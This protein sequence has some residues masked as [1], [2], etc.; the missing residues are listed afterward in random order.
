MPD[1]LTDT[2]IIKAL[3]CISGKAKDWDC[4]KCAFD[5]AICTAYVSEKALDLINRQ[6]F[7]IHLLE[8]QISE[9]QNA[10]LINW[11][12]TIG[13]YKTEIESLKAEVERL[14]TYLDV[15]GYST[16]KIKA[17]AYKE[18]AER[19]HEELRI[20]GAKDKFNKL[21]FLNVVYNA[22]KELVGE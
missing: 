20:Y 12:A 19:L 14:N 11:N 18:F 1:K 15:I 22:K 2:E 5:G 9:I 21:V 13:N 17:E 4:D 3:E 16:D 7:K 8:K 10:N 6:D